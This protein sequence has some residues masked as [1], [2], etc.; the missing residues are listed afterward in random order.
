[1]RANKCEYRK[2]IDLLS[3]N[4]KGLHEYTR[5]SQEERTE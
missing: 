4:E 3:V 2:S 5:G 1:M